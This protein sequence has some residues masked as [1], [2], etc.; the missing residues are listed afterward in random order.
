VVEARSAEVRNS[1]PVDLPRLISINAH[2]VYGRVPEDVLVTDG[3]G[4]AVEMAGRI[5]GSDRAILV[6]A[7]V[8]GEP[9]GPV[10]RVGCLAGAVIP[11]TGVASSHGQ[12][13]AEAIAL[14]RTLGCLLGRA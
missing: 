12:G 3:D 5:A 10:R 8:S 2:V 1:Q 14:A 7:A 13:V 4:S 11:T 9:P 6:D